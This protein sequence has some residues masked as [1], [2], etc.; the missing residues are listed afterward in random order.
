VVD[1][2]KMEITHVLRGDDHVS[3]TPRQI[4]LSR[5]LG[6]K[7]AEF[8]H[9]S[10]I[11]GPDGTRLSKRHGATSVLEYREAGYLPEALRNYLALLGWA[12]PQ[13]QDLF[14]WGELQEKFD[15][16]GCQKSPAAFN[17]DK[18][19]WM[20][21]EYLRALS[22]EAVLERAR[23]FLDRAGLAA[24]DERLLAVVGLEREKYK[25]LSDVPKLMDFFFQEVEYDPAAV[26][27]VLKKEGAREA[28]EGLLPVLEACVFDEKTLEA[29][30]RAF[31]EARVLKTGQ[32]F[33]PVRVAVS[34]RTT[35]P[36]LFAMLEVLGKDVVLKRVRHVLAKVAA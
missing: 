10:I 2:Y 28:L 11:L 23:P 32:V 36:S 34:G 29:R 20:N 13:S 33:H 3:N 21:G 8:G 1:D 24:P 4:Q 7:P 15:L 22:P 6:W 12:T 30:I 9:F 31:C 35:G 5:A 14:Q 19:L 18:L 16:A 27:K 17:P 25:L 26:D